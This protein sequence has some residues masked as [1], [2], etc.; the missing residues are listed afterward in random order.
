MLGVG[1]KHLRGGEY[2]PLPPPSAANVISFITF[3]MSSIISIIGYW[4]TVF[5][6][7]VIAEHFIFRRGHFKR[8]AVLDAWDVPRRLP[9]GIAALIAFAGAFGIIVPCMSQV[10]YEGPIARMG[11][12]DIGVL[13]G[14]VVAGILYV[15]LRTAEK[16]WTSSR[17]IS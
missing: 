14:F 3:V 10:W 15:P 2:P 16:R 7:I 1:G 5:A 11:T 8:Y 4:S 17:E 12:G 9:P 6:A 13:T